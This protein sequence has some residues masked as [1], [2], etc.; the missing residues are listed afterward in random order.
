VSELEPIRQSEEGINLRLVVTIGLVGV[1]V[2]I[3]SVMI[4]YA[5]LRARDQIGGQPEPRPHGRA[6]LILQTL[7]E[8]PPHPEERESARREDELDRYGWVDEAHEVARIP[9]ERAMAIV[10]ERSR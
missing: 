7:I 10:A 3:V 2:S 6:G 1:V 9:I 8:T 5:Y 4:V